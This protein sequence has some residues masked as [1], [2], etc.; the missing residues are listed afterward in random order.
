MCDCPATYL[1]CLRGLSKQI[2]LHV[3]GGKQVTAFHDIEL[4]I[5]PGSFTGLVG[6][7]G[8]GKSSLLKC[9]YRTYLPSAGSACYL[10]ADNYPVDLACASDRTILELRRTEI[11]F[12]AQFLRAA[13]RVAAIDIVAAPR[14]GQ[15]VALA[16]ARTEARELLARLQLPRELWDSYP[17]LFSG[18]EQQR[19]NVARG[20]ITRPRLLLLDEPTSAL[21][22]ESAALVTA[23]LQEQRARGATLI[24]VFHDPRMVATL[25]DEVAV[26]QGGR[27]VA[28]RRPGQADLAALA[29]PVN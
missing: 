10:T 9:I 15:G 20:L 5:A 29:A 7:S 1:L 27:L 22:A 6:P 18:G 21:D 2:T 8:S 11:G 24:G 4:D 19:V 12:V 13:P 26:L 17:A 3:L 25:C 23:L 28:L 14:A 16:E